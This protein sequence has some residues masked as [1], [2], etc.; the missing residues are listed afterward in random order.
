MIYFVA[1]C[2]DEF[3]LYFILQGLSGSIPKGCNTQKGPTSQGCTRYRRFTKGSQ[4]IK[5]ATRTQHVF[6][7]PRRPSALLNSY[8]IAHT[9]P[10]SPWT[11][12]NGPPS[13]PRTK[14]RKE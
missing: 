9:T 11:K 1:I 7:S 13:I 4:I 14:Y 8:V 10:P 5:M 2:V 6:E 3:E 12:K